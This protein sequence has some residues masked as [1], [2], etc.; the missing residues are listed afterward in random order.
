MKNKLTISFFCALF[1]LAPVLV[2]AAANTSYQPMEQIPGAAELTTGNFYEYIAGIY[3]FGIWGVGIAAFLMIIIGGFMYITSAGNTAS[4]GKAK[5]VI[6]DAVIGLLLAM[7]SWLLL[8]IINPDLVTNKPMGSIGATPA[9]QGT[10]KPPTKATGEDTCAIYSHDE[11]NIITFSTTAGMPLPS[12]CSDYEDAFRSAATAT[13]I[14]IKILRAIAS[15]E[16]TCGINLQSKSIPPSCGLMQLQVSTAQKY[17]AEA[18]SC[19][20]L[21]EHPEK[22]ILIA[23]KYIKANNGSSRPK[24]ETFAGYNAGYGTSLTSAGKKPAFYPSSDCPGAFA[25]QCCINPG[26]LAETQGHVYNSIRYYN[27]Q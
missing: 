21:K 11:K 9:T 4:M 13:G 2:F 3:K 25:Y 16:S 1:F 18:T 15:T 23:A 17:D 7:L 10:G 6:T 26:G 24:E 20:W 8:Y 22:S 27:N 5:D 12:G 14:D 19:Q